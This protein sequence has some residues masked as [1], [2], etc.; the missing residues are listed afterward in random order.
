MRS[1]A[2]EPHLSQSAAR[3]ARVWAPAGELLVNTSKFPSLGH[4]TA[5]GHALGLTV[6]WYLNC[7]QCVTTYHN[8]TE[9]WFLHTPTPK[10]KRPAADADAD[11]A[12]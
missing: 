8:V 10:K 2:P 5:H 11:V 9:S 6:S 4:M 1:A 3:L 12:P 7:D